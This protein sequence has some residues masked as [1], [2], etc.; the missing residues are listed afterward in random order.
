MKEWVSLSMSFMNIILNIIKILPIQSRQRCKY[1]FYKTLIYFIS[2]LFLISTYIFGSMAFY[3]FLV[4][5]WGVP[6]SA[7]ALCLLSLIISFGL[8]ITG[9]LLKPKKK[10]P[11][12]QILPLL[13]KS[14]DHLPNSQDLVKTLNKA[15]P[16]IL[17]T[18]LGV[19]AVTTCIV[20]FK[21][22]EK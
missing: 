18:V 8:I 9:V 19:A 6:L 5:Y 17:L 20:L 21:K 16:A 7:F 3:S 13:E 4:P 22:N 14:L 1:F 2:F 15:S 12:P 10:K 11:S